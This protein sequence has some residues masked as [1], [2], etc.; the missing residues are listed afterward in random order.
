MHERGIGKGLK[1]LL[2]ERQGAEGQ[3]LREVPIDLVKPNPRQPRSLFDQE[4][5]S[6]LTASIKEHG[7]LQPLLV[8]ELA[9]GSYQLIAGERRLRAAKEAGLKELPVLLKN[10]SETVE[11][12]SLELAVVENM[13]R[14]DLNPIEEALA[15]AALA[16]EQNLTHEAVG[17]KVGRSRVAV[18]NLLRLLELPEDVQQ[19]LTDGRLSEGH[20][21]AILKIKGEGE[22]LRAAEEISKRGL[23][24]R[25]AEAIAKSPGDRGRKSAATKPAAVQLH[26]DLDQARERAEDALSSALG[27]EAKVQIK[28]QGVE[29]ELYFDSLEDIDRMLARFDGRIAA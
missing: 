1:A 11:Q 14:D 24:V 4:E 21:R 3:Q 5:L 9:G 7:V 29:A 12:E 19:M 26:P 15:C 13:V 16:K 6:G 22:Q 17:R 23:S 20:G 28:G 25:Q 2:G 10:R 27:V 8:S 18:T